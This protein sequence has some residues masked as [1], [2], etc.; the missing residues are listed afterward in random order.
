[1]DYMAP[2]T[3]MFRVN[4]RGETWYDMDIAVTGSIPLPVTNKTEITT[5]PATI[6]ISV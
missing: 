4:A 2:A 3:H 6:E 1:M 5:S